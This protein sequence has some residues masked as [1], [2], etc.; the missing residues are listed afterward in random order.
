MNS[1]LQ[2]INE[3]ERTGSFVARASSAET[4]DGVEPSKQRLCLLDL[5]LDLKRRGVM[6]REEVREQVDTF[7][8]EVRAHNNLRQ[9]I[10]I[11]LGPRHHCH[12]AYVAV[13]LPWSLSRPSTGSFR[14]NTLI[15][16]SVFGFIIT[17]AF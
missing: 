4:E 8:F 16:A 10:T 12:G 17:K 7:M 13:L 2:V 14:R 9:L 1:L 6:T 3:K 15:T 11:L 5:L